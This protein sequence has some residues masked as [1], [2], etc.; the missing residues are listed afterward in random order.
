MVEGGTERV[1][2]ALKPLEKLGITLDDIALRA[3]N[4]H[5]VFMALTGQAL[6]ETDA[7]AGADA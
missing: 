5:E 2:Q 1:G 7:P 4:L 3:P 6:A